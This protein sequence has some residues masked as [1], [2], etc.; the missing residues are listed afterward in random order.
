MFSKLTNWLPVADI[1]GCYATLSAYS[2]DLAG[3]VMDMPTRVHY[4][5]NSEIILLFMFNDS[6]VRFIVVWFYY[7]TN[8][9]TLRL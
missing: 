3:L 7:I 1:D 4:S 8:Q 2:F 5:N 6:V 9:L